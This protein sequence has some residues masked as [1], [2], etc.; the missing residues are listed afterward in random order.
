MRFSNSYF[1]EYAL[2][3]QVV[4]FEPSRH[5]YKALVLNRPRA[6][7][8]NMALCPTE[9]KVTF[10]ENGEWAVNAV[11]EEMS[12]AFKMEWHPDLA[13]EETYEVHCGPI[14]TYLPLVGVLKVDIWFLDV[15]GGELQAL[16]SIDF[17]VISVH[18]IVIELSGRDPKREADI[19]GYLRTRGFT[20]VFKIGEDR[21]ELFENKAF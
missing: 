6:I 15:E 5:S 19:R 16:K 20:F 10:V 13:K 1:Y 21:N 3:W 2:E 7:N 18:Y 12:E 4:H 14:S 17:S 9:R 11:V 8:F